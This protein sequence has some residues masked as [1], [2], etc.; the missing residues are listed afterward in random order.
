MAALIFV[1]KNTSTHELI[2]SFVSIDKAEARL[3]VLGGAFSIVQ[4][5]LTDH[6]LL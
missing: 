4:T 2:E 6:A 3:A 1:I 5:S